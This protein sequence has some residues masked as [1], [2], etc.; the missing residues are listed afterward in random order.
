MQTL[1]PCLRYKDAEAAIDFLVRAFG[2]EVA[3]CHRDD[4]GT[5]AHAELSYGPSRLML[6]QDRGDAD[7]V[8]AGH[9]G[10]GWTYVAV[11][12]A[13]A[14]HAQAVAAGAEVTTGLTDQDYGSRDYAAKDPEGNQWNFGTYRPA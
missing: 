9:L 1:Y 4:S 3:E 5:I 12:D 11:E 7:P 13:D 14:H 2:F 8:H 10:H 6:G